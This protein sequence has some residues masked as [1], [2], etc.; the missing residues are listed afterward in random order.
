MGIW[1]GNPHFLF[2]TSR[3]ALFTRE[4]ESLEEAG[5]NGMRC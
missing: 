3:P 1:G 4:G 5:H 2:A